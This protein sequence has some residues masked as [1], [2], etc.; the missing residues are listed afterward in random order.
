MANRRSMELCGNLDMRVHFGYGV[1][2]GR[3]IQQA[4]R[5]SDALEPA[6]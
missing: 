5:K 4:N 3:P 2:N 1:G 6:N